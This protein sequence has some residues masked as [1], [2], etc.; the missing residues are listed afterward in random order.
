MYIASLTKGGVKKLSLKRAKKLY[1][2]DPKP[3]D[4]TMSRLKI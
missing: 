3:M 1:I 2:L 4:L